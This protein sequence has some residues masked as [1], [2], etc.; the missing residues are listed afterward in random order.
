MIPALIDLMGACYQ[1]GNPNQMAVIARSILTSIPE[2]VV[3][4]QFLGLALYQM[5]RIEAARQAFS[6]V[7]AR[8]NMRRKFD[9]ATTEE[10]AATTLYRVASA[11]ASGLGDA[12]QHIAL[13]MRRLGF[14]SAA[15]RAYQTSLV[16]RG[17]VLRSGTEAIPVSGQIQH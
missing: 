10:K 7:R 15:A 4:L 1:A 16:A 11:P 6:R 9:H 8:P 5:G 17:L 2:D 3:A 12:W 13:A 14:R